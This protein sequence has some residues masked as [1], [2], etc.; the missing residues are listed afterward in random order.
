VRVTRCGSWERMAAINY[1]ARWSEIVFMAVPFTAIGDIV[2]TA[3]AAF[4]G[5][6][7]VDVTNALNAN[8]SFAVGFTTSGA[9]ELQEKVSKARVVK[10]FNTVFAAHMETGRVGD[11]ALTAFVAGDNAAAKGAVPLACDIGFDPVDAARSRTRASS[12]R[13]R[14]STS[15]SHT[16]WDWARSSGSTSCAG[17]AKRP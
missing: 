4:D 12:S 6:T 1:A 3:G 10:A 7:L 11:Q 13:W 8:M 9:E 17:E 15:S 14:S 5:K 2:K 16:P